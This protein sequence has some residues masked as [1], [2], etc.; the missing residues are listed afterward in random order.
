MKFIKEACVGSLREAIIAEKKGADRIEL[1]D[2]LAMGGTTQSLGTIEVAKE[3]LN[4][5][6]NAIIRPRGGDFVYDEIEIE[7]MKRD[8]E[9]CKRIGIN[10]VVIGVLDSNNNIDTEK[11]K[12]ILKGVEDMEVTFHMAFDEVE[13]P[14]KAID[15]LADLGINRIL[16][17]GGKEG[18]AI[19]NSEM[20][21]KYIE[22]S[23]ERIIILPGSGITKENAI[24]LRENTNALELH[25]TKI[26]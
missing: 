15:L 22:Y 26:V 5:P 11:L 12:Y 24:E 8:I 9:Q 4:I 17:K 16:T 10:G 7:I 18:T 13:E 21:K 1:C 14:F 19:D 3:V 20:L 6:V 2:N 25:G 23:K